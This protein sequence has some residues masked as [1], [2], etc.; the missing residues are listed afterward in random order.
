MSMRGAGLYPPMMLPVGMQHISPFSAMGVAMQMRLGVP[1]F[2]GTHIPAAYAFGLSSLH[3]MAA[4][5]N[6]QMF[7]LPGPRLH[8]PMPCS[9]TF[10]YPRE[11][12]MNS[13]NPIDASEQSNLVLNSGRVSSTN[14]EAAFTLGNQDNAITDK[15]NE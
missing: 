8:M 7:G 1:Q 15:S 10:S 11:S 13:A 12:V 4:R 14:D 5:P 6:P 3:G 9:P 2:Q